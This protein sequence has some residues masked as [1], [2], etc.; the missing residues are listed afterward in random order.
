MSTVTVTRS[1]SSATAGDAGAGTC[2]F[3][4]DKDTG[5]ITMG[6]QDTQMWVLVWQGLGKKDLPVC[7]CIYESTDDGGEIVCL[8]KCMSQREGIEAIHKHDKL[9]IFVIKEAWS[10]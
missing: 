9:F 7:G 3:E 6:G 10:G 8:R 2:T 4:L 5:I 1:A